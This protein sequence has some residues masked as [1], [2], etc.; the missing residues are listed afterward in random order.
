M[1]LLF[2]ISAMGVGYVY[3]GYPALLVVWARVRP[4]PLR[5]SVDPAA[6]RHAVL[7]RLSIVIAARNEAARLRARIEN[8]LALDYPSG[9]REILVV[10]DGSTDNTMAVLT[11]YG[12]VLQPLAAPRGG[13][14]AALNLGVAHASGDILIFA[15]ARQM[16]APNALRALVAPFADPEV[17]GVTGELLL[18]CEPFVDA[19]RPRRSRCPRRSGPLS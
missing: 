7:P 4:R 5:T 2:W 3:V 11:Q 13:K 1:R 16:F 19:C 8:L 9:R 14:A 12:D 6:G 18:D 10:S 15:D 17:G